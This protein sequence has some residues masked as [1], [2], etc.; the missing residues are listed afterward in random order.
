MGQRDRK[1]PRQS[2]AAQVRDGESDDRAEYRAL[3]QIHQLR[4]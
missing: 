3:I 4:V 2:R 1:A